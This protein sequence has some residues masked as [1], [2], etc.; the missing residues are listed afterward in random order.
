[1]L[2]SGI[3]WFVPHPRLVVLPA[4]L[5]QPGQADHR[6]GVKI[7]SRFG[8]SAPRRHTDQPATALAAIFGIVCLRSWLWLNPGPTQRCLHELPLRRGVRL[9]IISVRLREMVFE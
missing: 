9:A 8:Y 7:R 3:T 2:G 4:T 1:V 6:S 5:E